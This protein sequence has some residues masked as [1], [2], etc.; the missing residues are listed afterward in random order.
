MRG[1]HFQ[2]MPY[3]Q[4]KLVSCVKVAVLDVGVD[5]RKGSP[6]FGQYVSCLLTGRDEEGINIAEQIVKES[7]TCDSLMS[8]EIINEARRT[9][10]SLINASEK[11]N[12]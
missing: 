7:E 12:V 2:R 1:L 11:N 10:F 5:I 9:C 3:T 6:T 8:L 4:S